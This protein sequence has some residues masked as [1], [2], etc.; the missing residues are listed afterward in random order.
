MID[1]VRRGRLATVGR[2][3]VTITL[4][5][6]THRHAASA[7]DASRRATLRWADVAARV[8]VVD[9][10]C[11][12]DLAAVGNAVV[13]IREASVARDRACSGHARRCSVVRA[14]GCVATAAMQRAR[15][16]IRLAPVRGKTVTIAK[17]LIA[18]RDRAGSIRT[19]SC[20]VRQ[21]ADRSARAAIVHVRINVGLAT[22][23]RR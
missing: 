14:A 5:G 10:R 6:S 23:A 9:V 12:V 1:V 22:V 7:V 21:H 3:A 20:R 15:V 18:T 4:A 2:V 11:R 19:S 8:A 16:Q 13:A 17:S